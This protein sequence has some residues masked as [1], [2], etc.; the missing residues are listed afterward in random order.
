MARRA[1]YADPGPGVEGDVYG[2]DGKIDATDLARALPE[3][4][5]LGLVMGGTAPA[6]SSPTIADATWIFGD[7]AC[8]DSR[9]EGPPHLPASPDSFLPRGP[10]DSR[11]RRVA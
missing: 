6:G 11:H 8:E 7:P 3:A 2:V 9:R 5:R 4:Q 1:P 10:R